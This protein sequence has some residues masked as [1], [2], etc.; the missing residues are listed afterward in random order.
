[1]RYIPVEITQDNLAWSINENI[2][3]IASVLATKVKVEGS[4]PLLAIDSDN[5]RVENSIPEDDTDACT[6]D[7][8]LAI[9]NG[10]E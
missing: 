1:M 7:K 8:F 4:V 9:Q 10:T 5:H 2:R 6:L 3:R